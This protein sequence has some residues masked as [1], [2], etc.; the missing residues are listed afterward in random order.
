M[1]LQSWCALNLF[2]MLE[3]YFSQ[4]VHFLRRVF[5]LYI[6]DWEMNLLIK[7]ILGKELIVFWNL[8]VNL[9]S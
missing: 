5:I 1:K 6:F 9:H 2:D 8:I 3:Y 4:I 7:T